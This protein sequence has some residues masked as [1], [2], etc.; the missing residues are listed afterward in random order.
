VQAQEPVLELEPE[1]VLV[2]LQVVLLPEA[3]VQEQLVDHQLETVPA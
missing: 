2:L 1:P 3:V